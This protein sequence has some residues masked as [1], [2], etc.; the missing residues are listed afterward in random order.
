MTPFYF[1][2]IH[3]PLTLQIINLCTGLFV[4]IYIMKTNQQKKFYCVS[5]YKE[6]KSTL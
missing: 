6:L 1:A 4:G 3:Y 5:C 2:C